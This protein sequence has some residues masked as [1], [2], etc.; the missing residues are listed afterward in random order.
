MLPCDHDASLSLSLFAPSLSVTTHFPFPFPFSPF[1][2]SSFFLSHYLSLSKFS[3][4]KAPPSL[5]APPTLSLSFQPSSFSLSSFKGLYRALFLFWFF[6]FGDP[7]PP[8]QI[9]SR[10][11]NLSYCTQERSFKQQ[12][13][14]S[15]VRY[16]SKPLVKSSNS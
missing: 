12:K 3:A 11:R 8:L 13:K 4:S 14:K 6:L 9:C 15:L 1:K 2:N 10:E 16:H 5:R 7:S